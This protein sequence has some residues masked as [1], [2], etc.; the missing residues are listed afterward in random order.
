MM[1][2]YG[3]IASYNFGVVTG[4]TRTANGQNAGVE[5][6]VQKYDTF[7]F[8][9]ILKNFLDFILKPKILF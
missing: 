9:I 4:A 7:I 1:E 2:E 5:L 6:A 3:K 8:N